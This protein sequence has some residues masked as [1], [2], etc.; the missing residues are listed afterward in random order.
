ML[1]Y[2]LGLLVAFVVSVITLP[3]IIRFSKKYGFVDQPNSR[4][5]H[6]EVKPRL[7]GIA[8]ILGTIAGCLILMPQSEY[9]VEIMIGAVILVITGIVDDR[10]ALSAKVK[11]IAQI[12]SAVVVV[13]SGLRIE[14][15]SLPFIEH[16]EFGILSYVVTVF[17]I[18]AIVNS[19]NLIDGLDGLAGGVATIA[20]ITILVMA[21]FNPIAQTTVIA[22]SVVLIGSTVGFLF[23]NFHPAKLFMG[24][25]G[26]LFLGYSIAIISILGFYKSVTAL[27]LLVPLIILG[28][29]II[30]TFFAIIRR[31]LNKQKISAPDKGHLHHRLLEMGYGHRETV[32]IIYGISILFSVAALALSNSA[33]WG[34]L[35]II[36]VLMVNIQLFAEFIGLIGKERAPILKAVKKLS[37][38]TQSLKRD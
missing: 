6:K 19:I 11:I 18:V 16:L 34:S 17:W 7:G 3:F 36:T 20:I 30:D 31:A 14:Y 2:V 33:F 21:L 15:V 35:I 27:S 23:Y 13:S 32:M 22:F 38:L 26:S 10:Y 29:P 5:V 9:M 12:A 37:L 8:I 1:Y 4:K 24:D 25:T 28:V